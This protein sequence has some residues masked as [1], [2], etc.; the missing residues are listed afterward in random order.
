MLWLK[1]SAATV[2][3]KPGVQKYGDALVPRGQKVYKRDRICSD[4]AASS[5]F[6]VRH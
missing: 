4:A 5:Y 2:I 3:A 6:D 1:T